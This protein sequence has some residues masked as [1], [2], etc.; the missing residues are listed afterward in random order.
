[1]GGKICGLRYFSGCV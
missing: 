1:L